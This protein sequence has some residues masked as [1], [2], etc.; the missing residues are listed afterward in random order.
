MDDVIGEFRTKCGVPQCFGA[1]DGCHITICAPNEQ[2]TNYYNRK[3]WYSMIVQGLV[4]ANY[5]F[6]DVCIGWP[7]SLHD[8]QVF[9]HSNLYKK[10]TQG[11]L[12]P[13][14][15]STISGVCVQLYIIGDSMQSRLMKPFA[16]NSSLTESQQNF[17]YRICRARIVTENAFGCL[18]A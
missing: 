1:V 7:G 17:N 12:V 11:H 6:L 2:H 9:A 15:S 3:G 8:A 10:I 18:K 13:N 4:D 5:R 14:Q 16:H